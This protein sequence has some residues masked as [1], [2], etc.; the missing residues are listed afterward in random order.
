MGPDG[1]FVKWNT[2][3]ATADPYEW[4]NQKEA[5]NK[6]ATFVESRDLIFPIPL[7]EITMSNGSIEQNP[8]W[9]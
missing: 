6:G 9:N 3:E 8:G 1:S 4:E 2:N 5:S 7:Y